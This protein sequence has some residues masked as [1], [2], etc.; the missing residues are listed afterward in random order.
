MHALLVAAD[1]APDVGVN[2][3]VGDLFE[4]LEAFRS[5]T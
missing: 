3:A 2:H 1:V 4:N 5:A